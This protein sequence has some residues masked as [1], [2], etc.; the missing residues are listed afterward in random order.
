MC[1]IAGQLGPD[2]PDIAEKMVACLD[3]RGPDGSGSWNDTFGPNACVSFGHSRLAIFDL[4]GSQQP[5]GS[6]HGCVLIQNGEIYNHQR[7]RSE[8]I[9]PYRTNGDS[10]SILA[11]H[12]EV[13]RDSNSLNESPDGQLHGWFRISKGPNRALRHVEWI[14]RLDGIWGFALWDPRHSELILCR[15]PLGVKPLL[16]WQ[17]PGGALLF[18]SEAKSF[19][20]HPDYTPVLDI[21][22]LV[23]RLA[24][25]YPLD[26]TTL[27]QGVA[28]VRP[29]TVETWAVDSNGRATL[30]GVAQYSTDIVAPVTH[31][32]APTPE[33][34]LDSLRHDLADR[35]MSD[36]PVGIVLS[37]G[38]DSSLVAALASQ[39][40]KIAERPVPTC[41]TLTESE[42]NPDHIAAVDVA[43]AMDLGHTTWTMDDDVFWKRL[44]DLGWHGEDLDVSVLFFQPLF[45]KMA[46]NVTVG[47]CG[48]GADELHAGYPRYRNLRSHSTEVSSRLSSMDLPEA[49]ALESG[50]L[51]SDI[52]GPGQAWNA[53]PP[54][55][56]AVYSNLES[57]LQFEI[58]RGQ[59]TNFQLRLVDRHS[60][61][62]GLEVRV[63]FL[64]HRHRAMSHRLPMEQRLPSAGLEKIALRKAA[65]LTNLPQSVVDRPKLPA[66]TATSPR[67]LDAFL[68]EMSPRIR[69]WNAEIPNL[70]P[71]LDRM[72]E[73]GLGLRLFQALHLDAQSSSFPPN[74]DLISI[75]DDAPSLGVVN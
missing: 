75:L 56:S 57:A 25:E 22:A 71:V 17:S 43:S 50:N 61:A 40:A 8:I 3:H 53:P 51:P 72:P 62:H 23:A 41:W 45:E 55:P 9:Y 32:S 31:A 44:P 33:G 68:S 48:Q 4:I 10:E 2:A 30:T 65:A 18:S 52:I 74:K 15:D 13:I 12:S 14:Q 70:K 34:L 54:S 36:V 20:A 21:H 60:M 27:F 47:L 73:I 1:G 39:S 29:G 69:E 64:G 24:F 35:L 16:R 28:Q 66:G 42:D 37:G 59:L 26:N 58:D 19:R 6:D 49:R 67:L 7:I 11:A 46:S 5:I 63:P 38:L